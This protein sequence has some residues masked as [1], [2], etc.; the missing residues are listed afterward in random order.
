MTQMAVEQQTVNASAAE[1]PIVVASAA[2]MSMDIDTPRGERGTKR[3]AEDTPS[4]D[5]HKKA[6]IGESHYQPVISAGT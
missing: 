2:D 3:M 5:G 6:K 1:V 4:G